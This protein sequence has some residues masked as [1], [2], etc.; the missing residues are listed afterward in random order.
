MQFN[1]RWF[2][3]DKDRTT[4]IGSDDLFLFFKKIGFN[5]LDGTELNENRGFE[6]FGWKYDILKYYYFHYDH[7]SYYSH[8]WYDWSLNDWSGWELFN[9]ATYSGTWEG[10]F[11]IP[12]KNQGFLINEYMEGSFRSPT[13]PLYTPNA[14]PYDGGTGMYKI[15][16]FIGIFN[17]LENKYAYLRIRR[18]AD[19]Q[20]YTYDYVDTDNAYIDFPYGSRKT[21]Q[22]YRLNSISDTAGTKVNVKQNICTMI[23]VPYNDNFLSNLF[24]ITTAPQQGIVNKYNHSERF[25]PCDSTGLENKFFSFGGRNFY[26]IYAN[27]AVEL[28]AN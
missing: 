9:H 27:L 4:N 20:P 14:F 22:T 17:N 5:Y 6:S 1:R 16:S 12:L 8:I 25:E 21:A 13:T 3:N 19:R 18:H 11:F 23:K 24:L 28:P 26:G 10:L 7:G 15:K 2:L